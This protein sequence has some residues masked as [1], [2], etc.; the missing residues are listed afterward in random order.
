MAY[1]GQ[2]VHLGCAFSLIEIVQVIYSKLVDVKKIQNL[3]PDRDFICLSKGHGVMAI[4]ACLYELEMV[5]EEEI[6]NYFSNGSM[7]T[8]LADSHVPGIEVSG[9]SLGQ[10]IT[11]AVGIALSKKLDKSSSKT[12]CIVGDGEINEGSAWESILIAAQQQLSNFILII[13]ANR[14][15]AMGTCESVLNMEPFKAKLEAFNFET[16][17][18]NGH[19]LMELETSFR[20]LLTSPSN[21]PKA[22]VARTVKGK[23]ISF[24]E[25]NN[26]WHYTRLTEETY[27]QALKE[28]NQ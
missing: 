25:D 11:V 9:G 13:D 10:G 28:L 16:I 7:L 15:Q 18:C 24:M 5:K 19:N 12:Y 14:Y 6:N 21:K 23:G 20:T 8:G 27:K 26:I 4:Y 2:S 17:E 22:I 1:A 3:A